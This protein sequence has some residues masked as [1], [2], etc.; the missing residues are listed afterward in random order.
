MKKILPA[1]AF[2]KLAT[3][4]TA[5]Q[6]Q[7]QDY[8]Q[9]L[10]LDC[11]GCTQNCC[12][13]YFQHHT[14]IEWA[15]LFQGLATLP[16]DL[17]QKFLHRAHDYVQKAKHLLATGEHPQIMC[18]LNIDGRCGLYSHRLMICRLH[19][20]PNSLRYPNG[21]VVNFPGC[22]RSQDLCAQSEQV[23]VL[24]RTPLY[25]RLLELEAQFVG[26]RKIRSLPRVD[27]TLAEMLI[28]GPPQT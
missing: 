8:S 22:Y 12:T 18:P 9:R 11:D 19:G 20:V 23:P 4:Y 5:M 14:R 24:D 16:Q 2:R 10:G 15:Y 3:L 17:H 6:D 27:L 13:S 7:Y 21:R 25:I 1:Q 26:P 28:Q